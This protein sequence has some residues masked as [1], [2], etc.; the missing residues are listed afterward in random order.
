MFTLHPDDRA[1]TQRRLGGR[2]PDTVLAC[3]L[4]VLL[5]RM[6]VPRVPAKQPSAPPRAPPSLPFSVDGNSRPDAFT[7]RVAG[8]RVFTCAQAESLLRSS[9][10]IMDVE[11]S[12][13]QESNK[14]SV[15]VK[16]D[17]NPCPAHEA[18]APPDQ[19]KRRRVDLDWRSAGIQGVDDQ[20]R[21]LAVMD[22]VYNYQTRMPDVRFFLDFIGQPGSRWYF[23][24]SDGDDDND[25]NDDDA[26]TSEIAASRVS[27]ARAFALCF[28]GMPP[29][30]LPA[31][32]AWLAS[33]FPESVGLVYAVGALLVINV[34]AAAF[35]FAETENA[36]SNPSQRWARLGRVAKRLHS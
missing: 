32:A 17:G 19:R 3:N 31:F 23:D 34:R 21:I 26:T 9:A 2:E 10:M 28:A 15:T 13:A 1:D 5:Q 22:A 7:V 36:V 20:R 29:V 18:Y 8:M 16:R 35:D 11:V 24:A 25:D 30:R 12:F 4:I 14:I 6:R 27:D 33:K